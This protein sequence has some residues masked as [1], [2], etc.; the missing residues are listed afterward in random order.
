MSKLKTPLCDLLGIEAPVM[1]AG[2][3]GAVGPELTAAVSNA[4]GLGVLG[5]TSV[6]AETLRE[7]IRETKRLTDKPFGLDLILPPNVD[8]DIPPIPALRAMIPK[9][10]SEFV[11]GLRQQY[12][13]PAQAGKEADEKLRDGYAIPSTNTAE[14]LEVMF[15]EGVP[16]FVSGLGSPAFLMDRARDA[17][18]KVMGIT[19]N[20]KNGKRIAAAGVDAVIAQGSEGGAHTGYVGSVTLWPQVVDALAPLPVV[21][22]GGVGDGRGLAAALAMGCQAVWCG[23]AF[24]PTEEANIDQWRKERI[25]QADDSATVTSKTYTGK[26]C[27]SLKNESRRGPK[28]PLNRCPCR[29]SSSSRNPR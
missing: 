20:V 13:D 11:E 21:A 9:E 3:G 6:E 26:N 23:S 19:G 17:G 24:L 4:G 1:C 16:I 22:A 29:C 7:W 15:E 2:M 27:R 10:H 18:M 12:M 14:C 28:A 8:L 25:T 5:G